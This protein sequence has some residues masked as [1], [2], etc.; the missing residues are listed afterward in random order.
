MCNELHQNMIVKLT[1][2]VSTCLGTKDLSATTIKTLIMTHPDGSV[3]TFP[4][5]FVTDG[6]DGLLYYTTTYGDLA[7]LGVY[8]YQ[9]F[10]NYSSNV[11]Y[12]DIN[13]FRVYPNLI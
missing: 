3:A 11:V 8:S 6:T 12:S 9:I 7:Q 4:L 5:S 2:T 13:N 1:I 10:L